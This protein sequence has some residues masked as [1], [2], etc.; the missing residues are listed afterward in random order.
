MTLEI[1]NHK[2]KHFRT[3]RFIIIAM[4][5]MS[6]ILFLTWTDMTSDIPPKESL[7]PLI[8]NDYDTSIATGS[9]QYSIEFISEN[10][11]RYQTPYLA[12]DKFQQ[13][14]NAINANVPVRVLYGKW[15]SPFSSKNIH[16]IY[17]ISAGNDL[18]LPYSTSKAHKEEEQRSAPL[19]IAGTLFLLVLACV[20]VP[21]ITNKLKGNIIE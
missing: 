9:G 2:N 4:I 18:I 21:K 8:V 16:S 7:T 10:R 17:E 5:P 11:E 12:R 19:V 14:V 3:F 13:I 6:F 1:L 20:F 15:K